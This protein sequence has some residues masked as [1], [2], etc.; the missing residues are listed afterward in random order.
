MAIALPDEQRGRAE[1]IRDRWLESVVLYHSG[2]RQGF[3]TLFEGVA[4]DAHDL[5]RD[6]E[7]GGQDIAHDPELVQNRGVKPSD[8]AFYQ[9]IPAVEDLLKLVGCEA[10]SDRVRAARG[11]C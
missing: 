6:L 9:S 4:V 5:H 7:L 11:Q 10:D 8:P 1:S 3:R 2:K